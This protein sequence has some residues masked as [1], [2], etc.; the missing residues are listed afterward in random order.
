MVSLAEKEIITELK[1]SGDNFE[2]IITGTYSLHP[3]FFEDEILN[4]FQQK[5]AK[6][7]LL[8]I[9]S[10]HYEETFQAARKAGVMY[11]IEPISLKH[12]F[13]PK[14]ILM[15]SEETGKL[16]VGSANLT[17]NGLVRDG[18]VFTLIDY[19]LAK[20]YPDMSAV[21]T[22]MK[23]FL[24]SLSQRRLIRSRKHEEQILESL[25]VPWLTKIETT[26]MNRR[27][28]RLLHSVQRPIL[29]QLKRILGDEEV[30]RITLVSPFFDLNGMVLRYL[31][32]NF[33][34]T[35]QLFIQPD[36]VHNLP[37]KVIKKLSRGGSDISTFKIAFQ[38]DV[39]RFIHAK[40][41]LFETDK[42][43]YCLTGSAN[44]TAAGLLS[45]SK[46]GNVELCLLRYEKKRNWFDYLLLNNEIESNKVDLSS[47]SSNPQASS[48]ITPSQDVCIE[49]AK[50]ES[51]KLI[52]RFSPPVGN[53]YKRATI[54]I[55]RP[56]TV[57]PIIIKEILSDRGK[58]LIKLNE[59]GKRFCEQS[60]FV[61]IRLCR[62]GSSKKFLT[63]NK[64]WIS[65]QVLE[66]T[67]RKRD[68]DLVEKTK[69]RTGLIR[70]MN[71]LDSASEIPTMFLYY[72]Q[73][74]DFDWLAESLDTPRKRMLRRSIGEEGL[75][76]EQATFEWHTLT[77]EEVLEKI[78]KRHEKK[79]EQMI[80]EIEHVQDL[81]NR[82]PRMFDLF[83]FVNKV[84]I[85]FIL[86]KD[87]EIDELLDIVY[88]MQLLVGRK[89]RF[90]FKYDGLGYFDK[91]R[92]FMGERKF[93][94]IFNKLDVLPHFMVI[95]Q[96][97][98]NLAKGMPRKKRLTLERRLG[99]SIRSTC[100]KKN[101]RNE[102]TAFPR[103]RL[104]KVIEEYEEYEHFS[105][106]YK[107][108]LNGTLRI[109]E[110][111]GF[112]GRCRECR[113]MTSFRISSDIYL[114]PT[115][116]RK[117]YGRRPKGM[118][119]MKCKKC[120]YTEWMPKEEERQ[121]HF[122]KKDGMWM[123]PLSGKFHIPHFV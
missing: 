53:V 3:S 94:D 118:V 2:N 81:E 39:N 50:L 40:I 70:L 9:D 58:I 63:S 86:R 104:M 55:S 120:G 78:V 62:S 20:E 92:E 60:A 116:A 121:L 17:E 99:R 28:V 23:D 51:N 16:F 44:A 76:D 87:V 29:P 54:I 106:S 117:L 96:I 1:E 68:I 49:E 97:M 72:L 12:D 11:L 59:D 30:V 74:L 115:C 43:S 79:F 13:H 91:I 41:I 45:N 90:W 64:R 42:G 123:V 32:N 24:T 21:F 4:I 7:I 89:G 82:V 80:E 71:Q 100:I 18:E 105:F 113:R 109:I 27:R 65:T 101:M 6:R 25:D 48:P 38:N 57:K 95:S 122:C 107:T 56:V 88:R 103:D 84:V 22:E 66:Q 93:L 46:I 98:L 33:C 77:A 19:D 31:V 61:R 47:L 10:R 112:Q 5:D 114:C 36:R 34:D 69:G 35:I 83:L 67:P 85:W 26:R 75:D 8:M 110:Q 111:F 14:F 108:V 102:I 73:F 119:L 52:I 15:T 37:I